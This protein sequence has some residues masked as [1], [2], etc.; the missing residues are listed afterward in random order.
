[1]PKPNKSST[2]ANMVKYAVEHNVTVP[3]GIKKDALYDLL[4]SKGHVTAG[5]GGQ[6]GSAR[7]VRSNVKDSDL[8]KLRKASNKAR[9]NLKEGITGKGAGGGRS[10]VGPDGKQNMKLYDGTKVQFTNMTGFAIIRGDAV[11]NFKLQLS[12]GKMIPMTKSWRPIWSPV[13]ATQNKGVRNVLLWQKKWE[14]EYG[15]PKGMKPKAA[16]KRS[17]DVTAKDKGTL[18]DVAGSGS[19]RKNTGISLAQMNAART[20]LKKNLAMRDP[21][22]SK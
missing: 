17:K 21:N 15:L 7:K 9:Q 6:A 22:Y 20:A 14:R 16:E 5:R 1:M 13:D 12:N 11:G 4:K 2:K 8:E 10:G 18:K 19:K 3:T